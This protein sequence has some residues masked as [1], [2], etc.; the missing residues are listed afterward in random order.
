MRRM[1]LLFALACTL[2]SFAV[3]ADT[4]SLPEPNRSGG[5]SLLEALEN[6]RS[7][8][9]FDDV[10]LS[11]QDMS[12]MLWAIAGINR[13]DGKRVYPVAQ[14]RQDMTAYVISKEGV[15]RYDP[16]ENTLV[17]VTS[18]DYRA[19]SGK[20]PFVGS[21]AVNIAFVQNMDMWSRNEGEKTRGENFGYAHAGGMMQNGYLFAAARGWSAVI[22]GS[23][24]ER[25]MQKLLGVDANQRIR[26]ILS[27]GPAK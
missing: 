17:H 18:G 19:E 16:V 5:M 3:A 1:M 9:E 11:E 2:V 23:F 25:S 10:S 13:K 8:R 4:I 6:R 26:L 7:S 21:A 14:G 12:D 27:V 22:R 20:Q 15:Y 24:D